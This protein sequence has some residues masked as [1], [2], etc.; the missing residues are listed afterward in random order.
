MSNRMPHRKQSSRDATNAAASSARQ[1]LGRGISG[2]PPK[3]HRYHTEATAFK[4]D[5][6]CGRFSYDPGFSFW[7][8]GGLLYSS[9]RYL[10][11]AQAAKIGSR[12]LGNAYR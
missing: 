6:C 9:L 8:P 3:L 4:D 1:V 5:R 12:A 11:Q 10:D 2:G 7:T